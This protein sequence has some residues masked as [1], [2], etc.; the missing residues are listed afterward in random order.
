MGISRQY[1]TRD[2]PY[3][4]E[5]TEE[6]VQALAS[7]GDREALVQMWRTEYKYATTDRGKVTRYC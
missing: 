6:E 1:F 2:G 5:L 3:Y 7:K 4:K